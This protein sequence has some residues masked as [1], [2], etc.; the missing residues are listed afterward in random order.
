MRSYADMVAQ[1]LT[2]QFL[3][4]TAPWIVA[5]PAGTRFLPHNPIS[6]RRYHGENAVWLL[7]GATAYGYS[8]KRWLTSKQ[9]LSLGGQIR[10]KEKGSIIQY[11]S[12]RQERP[13]LDE[14]GRPI[15]D[16]SGEALHL[17][18]QLERPR[19]FSSVVF[20]AEQADGLPPSMDRSALPESE[21]HEIAEQML[22]K[23]G[24]TIQHRAGSRAAY[25]RASD[26]ITLPEPAAFATADAYFATALRQ[27]AHATG[28]ANRLGRDFAH[29]VGSSGWAR[30]ELR[31]DI[32]GMI[33]GDELGIGHDPRSHGASVSHWIK[34]FANDP[35]EIFRA[36]AHAEKIVRY[37][38]AL[39]PQ[40]QEDQARSVAIP[41]ARNDRAPVVETGEDRAATRVY[42]SVPFAEKE[43]AKAR[44]ARWDPQL[45]SWYIPEGAALEP[46][47]LWARRDARAMPESD[48]RESFGEALK[49]VGL[50]LDHLPEMDGTLH[51]VRVE[52]DRRGAKRGAYAGYLDGCPAGFIQNFKTGEKRIWKSERRSE[53]L[54]DGERRRLLREVEEKRA[55]RRERAKVVHDETVRLLRAYLR[56]T[57]PPT[58]NHP[59]LRR[60]GVGAHGNGIGVDQAGPLMIAGGEDTPQAWSAKGNL[61]IPL[62]TVTG[63]LIGVQSIGADGRKTFARGGHLQGGMYWL[64]REEDR[65]K[66]IVIAEGYA[67]AAT[68]YELT[69]LAVAA[70]F[71]AGNL[72]PVA[73]ACHEQY[74]AAQIYIAGDNDHRRALEHDANGRPKAN[75]GRLAAERAAEA[76]G[77]FAMLPHFEANDPGSDWN[78]LMLSK[79]R[80]ECRRQWE[81]IIHRAEHKTNESRSG[82][83]GPVLSPD[84]GVRDLEPGRSVKSPRR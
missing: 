49:D 51:R 13:L 65:E 75:V 73:R 7:S 60:K 26:T 38:Q 35:R 74:R 50:V 44:G 53:G 40:L 39:A 21:R 54:T 66:S 11:W 77:G 80:S 64:G 12:W 15:R 67:T 71:T 29:P 42:I 61:I 18:T 76:S 70:A 16:E 47:A 36:A 68:I 48:P 79:G 17:V 30:E 83:A 5:R 37:L 14:Q 24:A 8:D 34:L 6:G 28:H 19:V 9:V 55:A 52:G 43:L 41:I 32:A 69:G 2:E 31:A 33:L 1:R 45:R 3:Q 4:G 27:G 84:C 58:N 25:D 46:L 81:Q 10:D 63:L 22:S 59:Y 82:H 23:L 57:A 56:T 78:D 20:N 72:E 62:H